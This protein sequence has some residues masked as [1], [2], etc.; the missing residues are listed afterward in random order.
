MLRV[1]S[2]AAAALAFL[3][4]LQF[5]GAYAWVSEGGSLAQDFS[6]P[7]SVKSLRLVWSRQF[8]STTLPVVVGDKIFLG[9]DSGLACFSVDDGRMLWFTGTRFP[10]HTILY[11]DGKVYAGTMRTLYCISSSGSIVW[12][13]EG[14][15]D[16]NVYTEGDG[17]IV[18]GS[19]LVSSSGKVLM[20][21]NGT[22]DSAAFSG[23]NFYLALNGTVLASVK[24]SGEV[25]WIRSLGERIKFVSCTS[26]GAGERVF[27][28]LSG[29]TVCLD[30]GGNILWTAPGTLL[31]HGLFRENYVL[32]FAGQK[33]EV[34]GLDGVIVYSNNMTVLSATVSKDYVYVVDRQF[35]LTMLASGFTLYDTFSAGC[36][37]VAV[38]GDAVIG[39][40]PSDVKVFK[41]GTFSLKVKVLSGSVPVDG[42]A[43]VVTD[44]WGVSQVEYTGSSGAVQ[45]TLEGHGV[46]G[47][48]AR[49]G[50]YYTAS[51]Y[52]EIVPGASAEVTL[53]ISKVAAS[54]YSESGGFDYSLLISLAVCSAA[55]AIIA[56]KRR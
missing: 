27:A 51:D 16:M 55:L 13:M 39:W 34:R 25:S 36:A 50:G 4:V 6:S 23:A 44:R 15:G 30:G 37:T 20:K 22:V 7:N 56:W 42:V 26:A 21:W 47:I 1:D 29:R 41:S 11:F 32:V 52:V 12:A 14:F 49:K 19:M 10:V 18:L 9:N 17:K 45:F 38:E 43:V 31:S 40:S 28:V 46:C 8:Y 3:L 35:A 24:G 2:L 5:A 33:L 53:Y 48:E 54:S